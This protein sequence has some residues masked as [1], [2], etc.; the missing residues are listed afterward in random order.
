MKL[1]REIEKIFLTIEKE[2]TDENLQEFKN[3]RI[4]DLCLYHYGL[5][6]WIRNNLLCPDNNL[7]KLFIENG[8]ECTDEMSSCIIKLFHY[9]ESN[10]I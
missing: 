9:Y 2:F 1:Y 7:Y 4:S 5:G 6:S 8:I 10:K 3:T